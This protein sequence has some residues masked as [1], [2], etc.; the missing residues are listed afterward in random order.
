[1]VFCSFHVN[2]TNTILGSFDNKQTIKTNS[3]KGP[4]FANW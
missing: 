1:M 2:E 4:Y 3:K